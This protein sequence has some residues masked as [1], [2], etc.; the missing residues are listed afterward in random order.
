MLYEATG[1]LT[2]GYTVHAKSGNHELILDHRKEIGGADLGVRPAEMV[3]AA[4]VGCR[5]MTASGY[6]QKHGL[7]IERMEATASADTEE[8]K[9]IGKMRFKIKLTVHGDLTEQQRA[10]LEKYVEKVCTVTAFL[11]VANDI[12]SETVYVK[13]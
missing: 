3:L 9:T 4:I 7:E 8:L 10:S 6:A 12:E 1:T 2:S 11:E 13:P 5:L